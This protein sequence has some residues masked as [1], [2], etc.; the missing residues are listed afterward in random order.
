MINVKQKYKIKEY[1][2][3]IITDGNSSARH[4]A[5][6]F[7]GSNLGII[8]IWLTEFFK[9]M[10]FVVDVFIKYTFFY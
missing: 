10:S 1:N 4:S 3:E 9:N 8:P 5:V 7:E 6:G 2:D